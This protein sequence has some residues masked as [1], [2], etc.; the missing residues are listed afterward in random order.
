MHRP[1]EINGLVGEF[2]IH[3]KTF[4]VW[5]EAR[6]GNVPLGS[7]SYDQVAGKH[8]VTNHDGLPDNVVFAVQQELRRWFGEIEE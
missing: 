4:T 5:R 6:D 2:W 7:G 8:T 1:L 3:S